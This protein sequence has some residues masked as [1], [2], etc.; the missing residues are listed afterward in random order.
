MKKA[1]NMRIAVD[2]ARG[3]PVHAAT[4][5]SALQRSANALQRA[6][7]RAAARGCR[8]ARLRSD[9]AAQRRTA[10]HCTKYSRVPTRTHV[11]APFLAGRRRTAPGTLGTVGT[12]GHWS[13]GGWPAE[14][15]WPRGAS[16]RRQRE[17]R[18]AARDRADR[19]PGQCPHSNRYSTPTVRLYSVQY[20]YR[21]PQY[22]VQYPL[23]YPLTPYSTVSYP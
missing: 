20:G 13:H 23:Q 6:R 9:G 21:T 14:W 16:E 4:Q 8:V 19:Y 15:V 5:H 18:R 7:R 10:A 22:P 12:A 11:C 2:G 17:G 1:R 3:A